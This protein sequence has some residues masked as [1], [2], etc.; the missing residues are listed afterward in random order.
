MLAFNV[1]QMAMIEVIDMVLMANSGVAT[2]W[3]MNVGTCASRLISTGHWGCLS[4]LA[5]SRL[6]KRSFI[7]FQKSSI[8]GWRYDN[9]QAAL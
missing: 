4:F 7:M 2:A 1:V 9:A 3:A 6:R 8:A 5:A